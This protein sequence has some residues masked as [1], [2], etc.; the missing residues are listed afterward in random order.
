MPTFAKPGPVVFRYPPVQRPGP[1]R[2]GVLRK[3]FS[4]QASTWLA[5]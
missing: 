1:V 4:R 2:V 3:R 5:V